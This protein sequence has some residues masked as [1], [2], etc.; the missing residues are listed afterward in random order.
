MIQKGKELMR[1]TANILKAITAVLLSLVLWF[2]LMPPEALTKISGGLFKVA[3]ADAPFSLTPK[4]GTPTDHY[5]WNELAVAVN[6]STAAK[7]GRITLN[8]DTDIGASPLIILNFSGTFNGNNKTMKIPTGNFTYNGTLEWAAGLFGT[9]TGTVQNLNINVDG[10][11]KPPDQTNSKLKVTHF[12][13]IAGKVGASGRIT[14]CSIYSNSTTAKIECEE[15]ASGDTEWRRSGSV[16]AVA[17]LVEDGG[18]VSRCFSNLSVYGERPSTTGS[19]AVGG[20]VGRL[21][22]GATLTES[23]VLYD[24]KSGSMTIGNI[25]SIT[26][27]AFIYAKMQG[28]GTTRTYAGGLVG[29]MK[30]SNVTRCYFSGIYNNYVANIN[31]Y[32]VGGGNS[33]SSGYC[34]G[35]Y[36]GSNTVSGVFVDDSRIRVLSNSPSANAVKKYTSVNSSSDRDSIAG[37][38]GSSIFSPV[39]KSANAHVILKRMAITLNAAFNVP[40]GDNPTINVTQANIPEGVPVSGDKF[41]YSYTYGSETNSGTGTIGTE[42][43]LDVPPEKVSVKISAFFKYNDTDIYNSFSVDSTYNAVTAGKTSA[44]RISPSSG[45]VISSGTGITITSTASGAQTHYM[46]IKGN[47]TV[48]SSL[49]SLDGGTYKPIEGANEYKTAIKEYPNDVEAF[50]V[51]AQSLKS[52]EIP[53]DTVTVTYNSTNRPAQ[54]QPKLIID[55]TGSKEEFVTGKYYPVGSALHFEPN[56]KLAEGEDKGYYKFVINKPDQTPSD[57]VGST[58]TPG[59]AAAY[60]LTN[61]DTEVQVKVVWFRKYFTPT[62]VAEFTVKVASPWKLPAVRPAP[63]SAIRSGTKI[64]FSLN[65]NDMPLSQEEKL[66]IT[67]NTELINIIK[68]AKNDSGNSFYSMAN[69]D[70]EEVSGKS[71]LKNTVIITNPS[72]LNKYIEKDKLPYIRYTVSTTQSSDMTNAVRTTPY[73]QNVIYHDSNLSGDDEY[74]LWVEKNIPDEIILTGEPGTKIYV[75]ARISEADG[76]SESAIANYTYSIMPLAKEV[77][78]TPAANATDYTQIKG[79]AEIMLNSPAGTLIYY[80]TDGSEPSVDDLNTDD[81]VTTGTKLYNAS[82]PIK[83]SK[84]IAG[85]KYTFEVRAIAVGNSVTTSNMSIFRYQ[86]AQ[87][88]VPSATP[89]SSATTPTEITGDTIVQLVSYDEDVTL[90][91]TTNGNTP[92][93]DSSGNPEEGT[94]QYKEPGIAVKDI[95]SNSNAFTIRAMAYGAN[96]RQS[97]TASF[98][99][100][101]T[102]ASAP[103]IQPETSATKYTTVNGTQSIQL[104]GTSGADIYY[105]IDGSF[106]D[107][108]EVADEANPNRPTKKYNQSKKI[109]VSDIIKSNPGSTVFTICAV[110]TGGGYASSLPERFNYQLARADA[111]K[112]TP[113]PSADGLTSVGAGELITMYSTT[114]GAQIYYTLDNTIPVVSEADM[115]GKSTK[116]YTSAGI[117]MPS[118]PFLNIRAIVHIPIPSDGTG[119]VGAYLDSDPVVFSYRTPAAIQAVYTSPIAGKVKDNTAVTLKTSAKGA[120]IFYRIYDKEPPADVTIEAEKDSIFD[121]QSPIII[122]KPVWIVAMSVLDGATSIVTTHKFEIAPTLLAP[123]ASID[124]GTVVAKDARM[125]LYYGGSGSDGEIIYTKDS[126]DPTDPENKARFYGRDVILDGKYGESMVIKAYITGSNYTPSEV[127]SF[128]YSIVKEGEELKASIPSGARVKKGTSVTFTSALSGASFYYTKNSDGVTDSDTSGNKVEITGQP[129]SE[130]TVRVLVTANGGTVEKSFTYTIFP[131]AVAPTA[132]I[133][134]G[135]QVMDG[136]KVTLS[137]P[138]GKLYYTTDGSDPSEASILYTGA[139]DASQTMLLKAIA[140][141]EGKEKSKIVQYSYQ[142][143]GQLGAPTFSETSGEIVI[144]TQIELFSAVEGTTIYYTTD[145]TVPSAD[146]IESCITYNGPITITRPVTITAIALKKGYHSSPVNSAT[147][148]V[149]EPP[150]EKPAEEETQLPNATTT[151]RLQSRRAYS[152]EKQ[153]PSFSDVVVKDSQNSVLVAA[154]KGKLPE[155]IKLVVSAIES[156]AAEEKV[157]ATYLGYEIVGLFDIS[158]ESGGVFVQ[159]SGEVE[160]GIPIPAEYSNAIVVACYIADDGTVTAIPTRRD[161]NTA[162]FMTNHFSK[163]AITVPLNEKQGGFDTVPL[164]IIAAIL[165]LCTIITA[166]VLLKRKSSNKKP[167]QER[168]DLP[169]A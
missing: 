144:K 62:E 146:R 48:P 163:Y 99:Y 64:Q 22:S 29:Y 14:D 98:R 127:A 40:S 37:T 46:I 118:E 96:Y 79:N 52:G 93:L 97:T 3:A 95:L 41:G 113:A 112:A 27:K 135:S 56:I 157:V 47:E 150:P 57:T 154:E 147:Y 139:I 166:I 159:P 75:A 160:V 43:V 78:A 140:V 25:G 69:E 117:R 125:K 161:G 4:G 58:Y 145:G 149:I 18:M 81:T 9:L 156:S 126:S 32:S 168:A 44:P 169:N 45:E 67:A 131:S 13:I 132:S 54:S 1:A 23:M 71:Y 6:G 104:F 82:S 59:G 15:H 80:T 36:E 90:Y 148:T 63:T 60:T 162:Y 141:V 53:S 83:V 101:L 142:R 100:Q 34:A 85:G 12:G 153:G 89:P 19:M 28:S 109:A 167:I 130:V 42:A 115:T 65:P 17:G 20:L 35:N 61:N 88:A 7:A 151:D 134:N 10:V 121:E 31:I 2:G 77:T 50:T 38:L 133:P 155:D 24:N 91:Y 136:A 74:Q 105:T 30:D 137:A 158:I 143:A 94:I 111:P 21:D 16:G 84:L 107:V 66:D 92:R 165:L 87:A 152:V 106:P 120:R 68:R 76:R 86:L 116:K 73:T 8:A 114:P 128:T 108:T 51:V 164:I 129:D 55:I 123:K 26:N 72:D 138:E 70:F 11:I 102:R 119:Q 122:T 39:T 110:V 124:S 103:T 33:N 49:Y 5:S